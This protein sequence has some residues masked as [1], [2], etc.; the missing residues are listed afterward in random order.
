MA[1]E[2]CQYRDKIIVMATDIKWLVEDAKARNHKFETHIKE[3]DKFRLAVTRNV[4]WR[5]VTAATAGAMAWILK[6][7]YM[8]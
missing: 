1:H 4:M 8:P 7:H 3:S 5:T 6:K 2:D